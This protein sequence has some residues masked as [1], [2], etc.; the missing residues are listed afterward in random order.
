MDNL[1]RFKVI[2]MTRT[3]IFDSTR[4]F[5][6]IYNGIITGAAVA[7]AQYTKENNRPLPFD[8]Q[9]VLGRLMRKLKSISHEPSPG[10]ARVLNTV[11]NDK[12]NVE[13]TLDQQ[14]H[15]LVISFYE[16][17]D[18]NPSIMDEVVDV[19]DWFSAAD[20]VE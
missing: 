20:K 4:K 13:L 3:I 18:W 10:S 19:L 12:P 11:G 16:K 8:K 9:R 6:L 15:E 5:E 14:E 7:Q 17:V 2:K 1:L